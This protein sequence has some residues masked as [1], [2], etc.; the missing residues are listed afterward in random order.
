MNKNFNKLQS[1][2][3]ER[4]SVQLIWEEFLKLI[5]EEAGSRVVETW[6]KAVCLQKWNPENKT[7]YLQTPNQFVAKWLQ[8]HYLSLIKTHLARLLH[9]DNLNLLF[10]DNSEPIESP[11]VG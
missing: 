11:L 1:N 8:Q 9:T 10:T 6:F 5:K 7:V 4:F 3:K 2:I